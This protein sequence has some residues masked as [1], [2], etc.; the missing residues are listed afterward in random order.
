MINRE[1]SCFRLAYRNF[2]VLFGAIWLLVGTGFLVSSLGGLAQKVA[3]EL[4][5]RAAGGA[6]F[7]GT[8]AVLFFRGL[9]RVRT[10]Q[11]LYREGIR[12]EGTVTAVEPT[13]V[14]INKVRQWVVRF[15][16]HDYTGRLQEAK[17]EYMP[18]DEARRWKPG[19]AGTVRY[20]QRDPAIN[21]WI[22]RD[23]S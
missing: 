18:P 21:L 22:G 4:W 9:R 20:D 15:T 8:G 19:D 14:T 2:W 12:A 10:I 7:G 17:S 16:F 1:P 6:G 3:P 5:L 11:R 23:S 13:R